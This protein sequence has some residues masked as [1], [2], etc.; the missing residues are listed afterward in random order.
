MD[1]KQI[2]AFI[3]VAK[4][5]SFSKAAN[6]IFLS[7]PTIS[8][9]ISALEKELDVQLFDRTSKEVSLTSYGETFLE[10]ALDLI[11]TRNT[12]VSHLSSF[13][14]SISG[15]FTLEA[16][17]TPCNSIVPLLI[18]KFSSKYP[19]VSFNIIEQPSG[20]IIEDI[21]KFNCE[22]GIIGSFIK[23]EKIDCYKLTED[24]LVLISKPSLNLPDT[25]SINKLL[26]YKF[27]FR[28]INS[29]TRKNFEKAILESELDLESLNICCEVNSLDA[30]LQLVKRGVGVSIVSKRVCEDYIL[31][32]SIKFSKIEDV[33]LK[34]Y[35]YLITS[36]RRTLTPSAKAFFDLCNDY[37]SFK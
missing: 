21:L 9:Q 25:I 16:S 22:I 29:A 12:A 20:E 30:L 4:Y 17:S 5:K 26:N 35:M 1:F 10:Y 14:N 13:N 23:D 27:I 34:R 6:T 15:R 31:S 11:N 32:G 3:T 8:A 24:E 37:Y 2:E 33:S 36:S 19:N 18:D 7:Q 28:E